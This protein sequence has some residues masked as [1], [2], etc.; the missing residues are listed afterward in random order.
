MK[1]LDVFALMVLT[2]MLVCAV[3]IFIVLGALPGKV[4]RQRNH[5]QAG[6]ISIGGWLGLLFGGVLWPLVLMW[7]YSKPA[8]AT[9]ATEKASAEELA[10]LKSR[11]SDLERQLAEIRSS[12]P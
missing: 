2:I 7:A 4:A 12:T 10:R 3:I 9:Q 1:G 5:P 8:S 11:L 6:A